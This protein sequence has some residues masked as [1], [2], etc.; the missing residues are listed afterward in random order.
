MIPLPDIDAIEP[1]VSPW[2]TETLGFLLDERPP[3]SARPAEARIGRALF[4]DDFDLPPAVEARDEP[5][6]IEPTFSVAELEAARADGFRLGQDTE[7]QS[8]AALDRAAEHQWLEAITTALDRSVV[9][10]EHVAEDTA[11]AVVRLLL[12]TLAAVFPTMCERFGETEAKGLM[13]AI[14]P[15][16]R[17][18]PRA[19]IRLAP[20][21]CQVITDMLNGADRDLAGRVDI[22]PDPAMTAGDIRVTWRNGEAIRDSRALWAEIGDVLGQAGWP[23]PRPGTPLP[24]VTAEHDA[25]TPN[26]PTPNASTPGATIRETASVE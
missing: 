8:R 3:P 10:A 26:V 15:V 24:E 23:L 17:L 4:D 2:P 6:I 25:T 19:T 22:Q 21:L 20:A 5:E 11:E 14:L 18:E 1:G 9:A 13:R 7:R 12:D 16:L